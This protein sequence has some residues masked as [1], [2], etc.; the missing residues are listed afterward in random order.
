MIG[1]QSIKRVRQCH[2]RGFHFREQIEALIAE[3]CQLLGI[4]PECCSND[5]DLVAEIVTD[6]RSPDEVLRILHNRRAANQ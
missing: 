5:R 4:D 6:G 1:E 3:C 2:E